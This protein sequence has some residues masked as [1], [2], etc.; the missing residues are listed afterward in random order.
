MDFPL[1][2]ACLTI[3]CPQSSGLCNHRWR[4]LPVRSNSPDHH[5]TPG[6]W[7]RRQTSPHPH[8]AVRAISNPCSED[9]PRCLLA[10]C[11]S[12]S[13]RPQIRIC[14]GSLI[15]LPPLWAQSLSRRWTASSISSIS[16]SQGCPRIWCWSGYTSQ[17]KHNRIEQEHR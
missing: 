3:C 2:A 14:D 12:T 8:G 4:V 1:L 6:C 5:R 10:W 9:R 13:F 17:T 16:L 11:L 15:V 7:K